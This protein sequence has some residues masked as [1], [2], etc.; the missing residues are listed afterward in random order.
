M[1]DVAC[2]R[3]RVARIRKIRALC[4]AWAVAWHLV[5]HRSPAIGFGPHPSV[6]TWASKYPSL[7]ASM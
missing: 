2:G 6:R 4:A 3:R 5:K 1:G 7:A